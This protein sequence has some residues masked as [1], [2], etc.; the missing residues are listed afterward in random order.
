MENPD[1]KELASEWLKA[2]GYSG[3]YNTDACG[4]ELSDLMPCGE[5]GE[6]C[7]AGYK[8]EFPDG[9]CSCGEG[10]DWHIESKQ[11]LKKKG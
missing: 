8:L 4:C 11:A 6:L 5:P 7:Q 2:N 1:L 10:C 3:L 9:K